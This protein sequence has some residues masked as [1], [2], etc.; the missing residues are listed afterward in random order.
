MTGLRSVII[1]SSPVMC[2]GAAQL[3]LES[4]SE[5]SGLGDS[6]AHLEIESWFELTADPGSVI[7]SSLELSKTGS[8][9]P[10][11]NDGKSRS[12]SVSV[13]TTGRAG[14]SV[15]LYRP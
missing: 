14:L 13:K 2:A 10:C 15:F 5:R 8:H 12:V 4:E 11:W 9:R 6:A 1:V 3:S 7:S